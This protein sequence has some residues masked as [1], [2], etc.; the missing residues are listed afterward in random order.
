MVKK[1]CTKVHQ[2]LTIQRLLSGCQM[3]AKF[4]TPKFN[5]KLM[6]STLPLIDQQFHGMLST[7]RLPEMQR[8]CHSK[9][10]SGFYLDNIWVFPKIVVYTPKSSHFNRVFHYK[11]SIL[12]YPYFWKHPYLKLN[13]QFPQKSSYKDFAKSPHLR[14]T[15]RTSNTQC[16]CAPRCANHLHCPRS[17]RTAWKGSNK[18]FK[19]Y[20]KKKEVNLR[21]STLKKT[22]NHFE[23][24]KKLGK[25]SL[26]VDF[27]RVKISILRKKKNRK[28][29]RMSNQPKAQHLLVR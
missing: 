19:F 28:N 2:T 6:F 3:L 14:L 9:E 23:L 15:S 1:N 11:P 20:C 21:P 24:G 22:S 18:S 25:K 7:P 17:S 13:S 10:P 27:L 26:S 12:G 16:W 4:L 8:G 5:K 29:E